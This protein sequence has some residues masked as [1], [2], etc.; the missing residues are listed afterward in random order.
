LSTKHF[1]NLAFCQ[2]GILSA[3]HFEA[4]HFVSLAFYQLGILSTCH[5]VKLTHW[6][7]HKMASWQS[8]E[9][10]KWHSTESLTLTNFSKTNPKPDSSNVLAKLVPGA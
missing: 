2:L 3:W 1:V 4:W 9:L 10:I 8:L 5:N 7:V 6:Q